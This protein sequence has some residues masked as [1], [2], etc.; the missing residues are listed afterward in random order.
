MTWAI[1]YAIASF[2]TTVFVFAFMRGA[3]DY[4]ESNDE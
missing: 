4:N 2:I 3:R 1:G